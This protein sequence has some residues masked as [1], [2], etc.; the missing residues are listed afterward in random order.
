MG[1]VLDFGSQTIDRDRQRVIVNK[2][3]TDIPKPFEQ[4]LSGQDGSG[5][6]LF[7]RIY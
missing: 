1:V 7:L 2:M 5:Y 6:V 3:L 4:R